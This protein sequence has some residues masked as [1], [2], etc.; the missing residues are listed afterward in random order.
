METTATTAA[1]HTLEDEI[2]YWECQLATAPAAERTQ[3][4]AAINTLIRIAE[5]DEDE[6][7]P[8]LW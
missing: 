7:R 1:T 5:M 3:R 4:D 8:E 2:R 6:I